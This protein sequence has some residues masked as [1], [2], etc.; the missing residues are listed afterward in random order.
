MPF[1]GL[2]A[3]PRRLLKRDPRGAESALV[4]DMVEFFFQG[5]RLWTQYSATAGNGERCLVEAIRY[6]RR[7]IRS[8]SDRAQHYLARAI[9]QT[10]R[11]WR[12]VRE[13]RDVVEGYNDTRGRTYPEIVLV[14]RAAKMLAEA[15]AQRV[16]TLRHG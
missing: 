1:D 2:D 12:G 10:C 6:V 8:R 5:G 13:S 11:D 16:L 4:L 14:I 9:R 7:Q 15:D 3:G